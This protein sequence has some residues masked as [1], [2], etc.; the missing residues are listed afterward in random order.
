MNLLK[1]N[2]GWRSMLRH[3]RDL[4]LRR[5]VTVLRHTFESNLDVLDNIIKVNVLPKTLQ[6]DVS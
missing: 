6:L 5:D 2:E 3:T 1:L 4:E